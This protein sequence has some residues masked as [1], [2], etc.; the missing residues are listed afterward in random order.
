MA[1]DILRPMEVN[2][3]D[4]WSKY[5][6]H[7]YCILCHFK[8]FSYLEPW[9]T[10]AAKS[11]N[12]FAASLM[13]AVDVSHSQLVARQRW[14]PESVDQESRLHA[15]ENGGRGSKKLLRS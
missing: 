9:V 8:G 4:K 5:D 7:I 10:K 13:F 11:G 14:R 3:S 6:V 2:P 12:V 15:D 1:C